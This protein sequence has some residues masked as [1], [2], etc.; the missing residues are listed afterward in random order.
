MLHDNVAN[1][2]Q[3]IINGQ[4]MPLA[5]DAAQ[6]TSNFSIG[7][8]V[9]NLGFIVTPGVDAHAFIDV[10]VWSDSW[11]F[12]AWFPDVAITL[13][14]GGVDFSCHAGTVCRRDYLYT[15]TFSSD[16]TVD[17]GG[18]TVKGDDSPTPTPT[19]PERM[20]DLRQ[21]ILMKPKVGVKPAPEPAPKP[22]VQPQTPQ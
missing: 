9:Y 12:P 10:G 5:I 16:P 8:P 7:S 11:D 1:S 2:D 3:A 15:A 18:L 20:R 13:P 22:V 4:K 6:H 19:L 14:P 21:N 17:T